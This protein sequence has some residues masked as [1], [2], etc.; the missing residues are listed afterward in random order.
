ML[1]LI[2]VVLTLW[3]WT[4][5]SGL[6]LVIGLCWLAVGFIWLLAVTR[7][8]QRPTPGPDLGGEGVQ[9]GFVDVVGAD[10]VAPGGEC[11]GGGSADSCRGSGDEH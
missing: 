3:L 1:P 9:P 8:F 6:A 11:K 5:L 4:S 10:G 2:G 7:G